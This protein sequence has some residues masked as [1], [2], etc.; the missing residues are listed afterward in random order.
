MEYQVYTKYYLETKKFLKGLD[1][2]G[3]FA[4]ELN[5]EIKKLGK[6][7]KVKGITSTT[8]RNKILYTVLFEKEDET[9]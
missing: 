9:K 6:G 5:E 4:K 7:W 3:T 8:T 1:H 2:H